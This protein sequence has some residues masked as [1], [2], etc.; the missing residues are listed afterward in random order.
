MT[1]LNPHQMQISAVIP[2]CDRKAALLVLLDSLNR[3][4]HPPFEVIIVDSGN[5]KLSPEEYKPFTRLSIQHIHSERSVCIQRNLGIQKAAGSHIFLCDDDMELTVSYLKKL[6]DHMTTHPESGAV[7]GLVLQ[8]EKGVWQASYPIRSGAEL[9]RKFIFQLGIWGEIE[10]RDTL[11]LKR[12]KDYYKRK[13]NHISKAGWPVIT[14]FSGE[15]FISP[16]Y[17]LGASLIK[18]DWLLLSPYD[19]VLD[20]NG[21]GDNYGVALGFPVPGI[22]ILTDAFVYHHQE[23]ANRPNQALL[24]LR[25]VLALDYFIHSKKS[26]R[27]IK[28]RWLLWSLTGNFLMA[29]LARN[30]SMIRSTFAGLRTVAFGQNPYAQAAKNDRRVT[31]PI[32]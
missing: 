2:T 6:A 17:G 18:K 13:G 12:I 7:S 3:S 20:R 21:I 28:K 22:H 15:Y 30:G 29:L 4:S 19:E 24:Y 27:H 14:A 8:K 25:R 10:C 9:I 1:P 32:L 5:E 23:S 11:L 16:V 26:L 31:E